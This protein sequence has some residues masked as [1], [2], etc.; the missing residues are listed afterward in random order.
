MVRRANSLI[1]VNS[2]TKDYGKG[3]GVFD[4]SFTI[5]A[6]EVF[7]YL[8]PNGAG[9]TVTIR[10]LLGFLNPDKGTCTINGKNCRTQRTEIMRDLGYIPGEMV[11]FDGMTGHQ[12]MQ[13]I[14]DMH[15]KSNTKRRNELI[16][17]FDLNASGSIKKMSKGTRQK[18][19]IITAFMNDPHV[20]ILDEPTSGLDPLMQSTFLDLIREEAHRGKTILMSSHSF[21]EIE[22]SCTRAGI[23][24][25]GRL[26]AV[27]NVQDLIR[28]RQKNY[29]V[30][31][32]TPEDVKTIIN[33]RLDVVSVSGLS[34][35][36]TV[37]KN[38]DELI[39]VLSQC[40]VT[41]LDVISQSLEQAF[42]QYYAQEDL[43]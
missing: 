15:G 24:R 43:S 9:K 10:H 27:E 37:N 13:F 32:K 23:I 16:E 36:I 14:A 22:K 1:S 12:F 28:A 26:I 6:G 2:L 19:G 35:K 31:V 11:F 34:V 40:T 4:L 29:F 38:V 33:S 25:E 41:D 7:G 8:G 5:D 21:G 17:R 20:Y 3:R 42:L 18:L 30:A 39:N